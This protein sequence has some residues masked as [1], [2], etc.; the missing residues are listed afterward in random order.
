[1]IKEKGFTLL[2]LLVSMTLISLLI[3]ILSLALR[4]GINAY[5]RIKDSNKFYFPKAAIEGLLFRQLQNIISKDSSNLSNYIYFRGQKEFLAF[6]T[7]YSPQG[8]G[9]GGIIMAVYGSNSNEK[10][11][12]YAQKVI[13][14]ISQLKTID[15]SLFSKDF[16]SLKKDGW[17]I[18]E[19]EG[20]EELNFTFRPALLDENASPD[21]WPDKFNQGRQLPSEVAVKI[22][23]K[24]ESQFNQKDKPMDI[25]PVGRL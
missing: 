24:D 5:S 23:F 13:T 9:Q 16:D 1:M 25:I 20:L 19:I 17:K 12:F 11:F 22:V 18:E 6:T 15:D 10:K 8:I 21:D 7:T 14:K 3:V 4:S 2:E